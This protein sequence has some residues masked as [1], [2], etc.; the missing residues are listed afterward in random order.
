MTEKPYIVVWRRTAKTSSSEPHRQRG[1]EFYGYK[2]PTM[3]YIVDIG[4]SRF[5]LVPLRLHHVD[6]VEYDLPEYG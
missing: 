4:P 1:F 2:H 6:D 3:K 5:G